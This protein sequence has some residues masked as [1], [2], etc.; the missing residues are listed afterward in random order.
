MMVEVA[1]VVGGGRG[2]VSWHR[3]AEAKSS[4]LVGGRIDARYATA[5]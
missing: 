3:H 2:E 5:H 1:E 4:A